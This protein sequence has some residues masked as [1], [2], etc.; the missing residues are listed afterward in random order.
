MDEPTKVKM[1]QS[2]LQ[3]VKQ[4]LNDYSEQTKK[5]EARLEVMSQKHNKLRMQ[6]KTLV[7]K[8]AKWE[9]ARVTA[10]LFG[11]VKE[12][13]DSMDV[14]DMNMAQ[15]SKYTKIKD[16][17]DDFFTNYEGKLS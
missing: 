5:A 2:E 16:S 8:A 3:K 4:S 14:G 13:I 17:L 1:L 10:D 7:A 12:K 9:M 6:N 15:M 11:K